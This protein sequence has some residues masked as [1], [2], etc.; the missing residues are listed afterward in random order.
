METPGLLCVWRRE[1]ANVVPRSSLV[2]EEGERAHLRYIRIEIIGP[3]DGLRMCVV[4]GG[5]EMKYQ[6]IIV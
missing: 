4:G 3:A 5:V 2:R 1:G 6:N